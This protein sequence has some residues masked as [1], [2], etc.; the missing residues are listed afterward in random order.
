MSKV[1]GEIQYCFYERHE[2]GGGIEFGLFTYNPNHE[3]IGNITIFNE[4]YNEAEKTVQK[5]IEPY[6]V[7]NKLVQALIN[8]IRIENN[9]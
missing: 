7:Q 8:L 4:D 5:L 2:D 9:E 3:I 1:N 6:N